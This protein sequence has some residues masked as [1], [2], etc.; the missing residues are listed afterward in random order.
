MMTEQVTEKLMED[1]NFQKGYKQYQDLD[2]KSQE[3]SVKYV[4]DIMTILEL[5][6]PD[7]TIE[8]YRHNL[9]LAKFT[10]AKILATLSSFN[11]EEN[12]FHD[13][14]DRARHCVAEELVPMLI[15]E[16]PCG[17]CKN[18]KDGKPDECLNPK[19]RTKH[20]ES[21]FLPVLCEAL[22][23]YDIWNEILYRSIPSDLKDEDIL[24]DLDDE[25]HNKTFAK[26]KKR[27]RPKKSETEKQE[28]KVKED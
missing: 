12:D 11:Y 28:E 3:L 1:K 27:G 5:D 10:V 15:N 25:F 2:T 6:K 4:K 24:G 18:C 17:E 19:I 13:A 20:C 8:R 22:I 16:E 26:P 21:R 9:L 14:M 7:I 23:D